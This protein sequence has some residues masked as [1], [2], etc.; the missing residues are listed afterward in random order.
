MARLPF[1]L[2]AVWGE[3][4]VQAPVSPA[5]VL[6]MRRCW[7]FLVLGVAAAAHANLQINGMFTDN[8]VLQRDTGVP[9][10]LLYANR[11]ATQVNM[12]LPCEVLEARPAYARFLDDSNINR[13]PS[14]NNPA[15]IRAPSHLYNGTI[16]PLAPFALRGAIWYQGESDTRWPELYTQLFSDLVKS[17]R[18]LWGY[19]FPFLFVQLAPYRAIGWD[20]TGEGWAWLREAQT[21]CLAEVPGSGMVV[22]TDAGEAEDIHP[23]AKNIPGE[24]LALLAASLDDRKVSA[25]APTFRRMKTND[26]RAMLRFK[27]VSGG[28]EVRRVALNTEKGHPPG[29]GPNPVVAEELEGFTVCGTDPRALPRC[30][31]RIHS[32]SI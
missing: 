1:A 27:N 25:D 4:G 22:I 24:R 11:G 12:W 15:A 10:G 28:L 14:E 13:T 23:Q 19:E 6:P 9:I 5:K 2:F 26:R 18:K 32:A 30:G 20:Q 16:H 3:A 17:W 21:Q 8:M 7:I 29:Q 31:V